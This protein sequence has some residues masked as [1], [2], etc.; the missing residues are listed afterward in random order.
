MCIEKI[1]G[2]PEGKN[3]EFKENANSKAK[4]LSTV[5]AFSNMSGGRIVLGVQDKTRH[6]VGIDN[7]HK[8]GESLANLIH[9]SIEPRIIPNIEII[10]FR[11]TH[12]I[13]IEVYPSALRPHFERSKGKE[14]STYIR[15]GS[16]TRLADQDLI[17]AVERSTLVKSF[18]E[19]P[20]YEASCEEIDFHSVAQFFKPYKDIQQ[21]D[22]LTLGILL[23][24]KQTSIPTVSGII[25][26]SSNRLKYFPDAWIQAGVFEGKDKTTILNSQKLDSSFLELADE[27][28]NFIK[29]NTR[30]GLKIDDIHNNEVWEV[31]KIAL[32]EAIINALVH[33]DYSIRGA[34]IRI[35]LFDDRIEIENTALLPWGLTFDDLKSGVS[36]LRN[37][38]IARVFYE[39]GFIEQWGSGI[40]RMEKLCEEAGLPPPMLEEIGAR[41]RVTFYKKNN[42][43]LKFDDVDNN[44][45]ALIKTQGPLST[46]QISE[47][48][49]LSRRTIINRLV[50]LVNIG[51]LV[52]IAQNSQ[53][54]KKK[55]AL[56]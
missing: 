55:Y 11:N 31:P 37:P 43:V 25:I 19:E 13:I 56:Y 41:I 30:I 27:A 29:K 3:L 24:D 33:T 36:K 54:P 5:I 17:Q 26:C 9:D 10:P 23:K 45:I 39:L 46:K 6:I 28:L 44:I 42:N 34:P 50:R 21:K 8:V 2:L 15:I 32:R 22:L 4:I 49:S 1:I 51:V 48:I 18:D 35:S 20:C 7:P 16:T 52:E 53:D 38:V 47:H 14:K 40:K 12:C